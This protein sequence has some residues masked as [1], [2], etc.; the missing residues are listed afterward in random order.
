MFFRPLVLAAAMFAAWPAHADWRPDAWF[1]E[2]AAAPKGTWTVTG[3]VKWNGSWRR[4]WLGTQATGA[5]DAQLS[6]W[7]WDRFGGGRG[8]SNVL[9]VVPLLRLT[10]DEGRSPWF[11]E[12]GIGFTIADR[13][14]NTPDKQFA[15]SYN[16]HDVLAIG[17]TIGNANELSVRVTHTSNAGIKHPN[18][19]ENF[20][21][22]RW[23]AKF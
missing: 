15:T 2:G 18:P 9:G 3:G 19:G 4:S 8:S 11:F 17:R 14:Y 22:V 6:H 21:Q 10:F 7:E 23:G 13:K 20:L 5:I 12:G 1:I 16:F